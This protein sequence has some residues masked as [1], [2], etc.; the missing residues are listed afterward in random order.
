RG[1]H[2]KSGNAAPDVL[3][4]V[5]YLLGSRAPSGKPL[6][7]FVDLVDA[8]LP[9]DPPDAQ[10]GWADPGYGGPIDG[11]REGYRGLAT[12]DAGHPLPAADREQAL[13][14]Y[15][16]E[17][18]TLDLGLARLRELVAAHLADRPVVTVVTADH[19]TAFGEP[20]LGVYLHGRGLGPGLLRVPLI[21]H[22]VRPQG[23]VPARVGLIDLM[24]TLAQLGG[25]FLA[26]DVDGRPLITRDGRL[27]APPGRDFVAYRALPGEAPA[28]GELAVLRD[29]WRAS[30]QAD[31]WRLLDDDSGD[32]LTLVH[33]AVLAA[34][35]EAALRWQTV[36]A[37]RRSQPSAAARSERI[38][39]PPGADADLKDM[40]YAGR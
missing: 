9:Y 34:L 38:A 25:A 13:A 5:E 3:D 4:R 30:R 32:D 6:F 21:I 27:D 11:S 33:P 2:W 35:E 16:G 36:A 24:P 17:V 14:L 40:G 12:A 29:E 26:D 18:A 20:P 19:G 10:R 1:G 8:Q 23:R 7:L 37:G 22:G 15:D 28:A 39:L 31:G